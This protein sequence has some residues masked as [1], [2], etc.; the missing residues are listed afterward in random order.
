MFTS[1]LDDNFESTPFDT[2]PY[3]KFR[4]LPITPEYITISRAS[5]DLNPW[6]RYNRWVHGDV[7][8]ASAAALGKTPVY[9]ASQRATRPIIEF[10]ADLKLYNF[11]ST[12]I[13]NVDLIDNTTVDAF[14]TVEGSA[15]YYVDGVLLD[16]GHRVIFNADTDSS[17]RQKIFEVNYVEINGHLRLELNEVAD[18]IPQYESSVSV[19]FGDINSG[20]SWWFNGD[21]WIFAQQHD[22]IN[23]APLFDL[24][25]Q[26]G[27]SY[28]SQYYDSNF[29][30]TKLFGYAIGSGTADTVLGFPLSYKSTAGVGSYVFKNYIAS[31]VIDI[32][33]NN[34]VV[35]IPAANTFYRVSKEVHEYK[36]VWERSESYEIPI[37][38]LNVV[39]TATNEIE[40][41]SI[42]IAENTTVKIL[43]FVNNVQLSESS[44]ALTLV[45]GKYT[46][47]F[48][49]MLDQGAVVLLKIYTTV[50]ANIDGWYE[51][52]IGLTNNPLNENID[53][54]TLTEAYDH[55]KTMIERAP[56]FSGSIS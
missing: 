5:K 32:F 36:N 38:Q 1:Q 35:K 10:N 34:Q 25:D 50:P 17:V 52:P 22:T 9:P 44:T 13:K 19:N 20:K 45:N 51:T 3:D 30:G 43:V 28:S 15:G 16:K 27:I 24:Y 42:T 4:K 8:Q 21:K 33:T 49:E 18:I 41:T 31:D 11:G 40:L 54:I 37:L 55:Y 12:G 53:T 14:S 47:V 46:V 48:N 2:Y 56:G 39:D 29:T 26:D 6:S 7:I 23:Q